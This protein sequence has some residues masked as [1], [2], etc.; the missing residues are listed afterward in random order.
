MP[1]PTR[2]LFVLSL[3]ALFFMLLS[4]S[5]SFAAKEAV[6]PPL[7]G[8]KIRLVPKNSE[9]LE[10]LGAKNISV[11]KS[12]N[13]LKVIWYSQI[14]IK[15]GD[16]PWPEYQILL[17]KG[18]LESGGLATAT[19][20]LHP[21]LWA[22]GFYRFE[23]SSLLWAKPELVG[24]TAKKKETFIFDSGLLSPAVDLMPKGPELVRLAVKK[25]RQ[26]LLEPEKEAAAGETSGDMKKEQ[27]R[28]GGVIDELRKVKILESSGNQNLVIRGKQVRVPTVVA[29]NRYLQYT[30]L[31]DPENPLILGV[32]FRPASAPPS[33][34][35]FF[36]FFEKYLEYQITQLQ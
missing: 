11:Y 19:H 23:F 36:Q 12:G 17:Q 6:L 31:K 28:Y 2:D 25:F 22:P 10:G 18:V 5:R 21:N 34:K 8:L 32:A 29:G 30:I 7:N 35:P 24:T 4:P 3:F 15:K 1:R 33:L 20:Y 26:L 27:M 13:E 16:N 9:P 14:R